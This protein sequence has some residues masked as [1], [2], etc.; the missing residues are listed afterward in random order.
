MNIR[1]QH[2]DGRI[3][4]LELPGEVLRVVPG[5]RLDR[6]VADDLEHF[7]TK[8]GFYD[9]WGR[10]VRGSATEAGVIR[11]VIDGRRV[12]APAPSVDEFV[13]PL[14]VVATGTG[15]GRLESL[16]DPTWDA[17][18]VAPG[19]LVEAK[20]RHGVNCPKAP[21]TRDGYLHSVDDDRPYDIDGLRYCGRCHLWLPTAP[22]TPA[23][24]RR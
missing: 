17:P 21:H 20:V 16:P 7:F 4:T 18:T 8:D 15:T 1:V 2:E 9:G 14:D 13:A 22:A 3:E 12:E 5:V 19:A 10:G 11:D 23:Q 24:G 6:L